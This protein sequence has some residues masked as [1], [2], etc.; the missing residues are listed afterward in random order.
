MQAAPPVS[1]RLHWNA[2]AV[3]EPVQEPTAAVN[4]CPTCASPV[5][6]GAVTTAGAVAVPD[7]A[8][9]TASVG[10][11]DATALPRGA[12]AVTASDRAWPTSEVVGV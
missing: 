9:V 12:T 11:V 8:G 6:C 2:K 5:T 4:V 1:H 3:G 7:P 10:A